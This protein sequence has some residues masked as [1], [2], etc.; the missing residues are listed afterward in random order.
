MKTTCALVAKH[1]QDL[2]FTVFGL[3]RTL[4]EIKTHENMIAKQPSGRCGQRSPAAEKNK[5]ELQSRWL[6]Q[7]PSRCVS[8]Q[9]MLSAGAWED[10]VPTGISAPG[11]SNMEQEEVKSQPGVPSR[12]RC[13]Q[14]MVSWWWREES[15]PRQRADIR[16]APWCSSK[17]APRG[18]FSFTAVSRSSPS[19]HTQG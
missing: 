13:K 15:I 8:P 14:V 5:A 11:A 18:D 3:L 17:V 7:A 9:K 10:K 12:C 19:F 2:I 6:R 4:S 1:G 16:G